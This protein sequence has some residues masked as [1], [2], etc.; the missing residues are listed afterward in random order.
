M[1]FTASATEA[2]NLAI[3]GALAARP[4]KQ[5]VVVSAV[6]HPSTLSLLAH[7]QAEGVRVTQLPVD[8]EGRLDLA[9]LERA[10]TPDTA[11]VSLMWANNETGVLIPVEQEGWTW[12]GVQD[13]SQEKLVGQAADAVRQMLAG[14]KGRQGWP[15]SSGVTAVVAFALLLLTA[16]FFLVAGVR[17]FPFFD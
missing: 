7:L 2:N 5:H 6:E 12:A 17:L 1:V 14:E 4:G 8:R 9:A 11:L 3:T 16:C 10:I 13:A 15:L